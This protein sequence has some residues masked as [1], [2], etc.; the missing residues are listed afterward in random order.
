MIADLNEKHYILFGAL[1]CSLAF[2]LVY[3]FEQSG[4]STPTEEILHQDLEHTEGSLDEDPEQGL[5]VNDSGKWN[6][7]RA[8][9]TIPF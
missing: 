7:R 3:Y 9:S 4:V 6:S 8:C 5:V 2:N 1:G